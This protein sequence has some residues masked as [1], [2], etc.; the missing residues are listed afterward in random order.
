MKVTH[1]RYMLQSRGI[2]IEHGWSVQSLAEPRLTLLGKCASAARH[3]LPRTT[4]DT[5]IFVYWI[6]DKYF[7]FIV[8][9]TFL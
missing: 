3:D 2:E 8:I 7:P 1:L 9:A 6:T 5:Y 4:S